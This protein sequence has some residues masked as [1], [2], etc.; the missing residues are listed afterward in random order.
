MKIGINCH[1]FE[2]E[3]GGPVRFVVNMLKYWP[4]MSDAHEYVLYF[5]D[6]VP[7]DD[8][9][10]HPTF[11]CK[12]VPS[13][14]WYHQVLWEHIS[15][16]RAVSK[17]KLDLFF[18]PWYYHPVFFKCPK[19][20]VAAWDITYS[21]HPEMYTGLF[22]KYFSITSRRSCKKSDGVMTCSYFDGR[23]I[24]KYYGIDEDRICVVQ[25]EPESKFVPVR[26]EAKI[27]ALKK[28][29]HL[30]EKFLLAM[31]SMYNRRHIDVIIQAFERLQHDHPDMGLVVCGKNATTPHVDIEALLEPLR[32]QGKA[33]YM[34]R[35]PEEDM[36]MAYNA[37]EWY[38]CVSD[39]DGE[40]ILLK[41]AMR[42]GTPVISSPL[43]EEAVG[44]HAI[45][46]DDPSNC[47]QMEQALRKAFTSTGLREDLS[48]NGL[49]WAER[50]NSKEN[51]EKG[52]R[53]LEQ[54]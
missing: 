16:A 47:D 32:A 40:T 50:F 26:D 31:G 43:L 2:I 54:C 14:S 4:Q 23:Q 52:L 17:D 29:H 33:V 34:Q 12:T 38:I 41:E 35:M 49:I 6:E 22:Q 10:Q 19:K 37:A 53:F 11:T 42:C 51:A 13:P 7:D 18:S 44:E 25:F 45:M 8:F 36:V 21:T 3:R 48:K 27:A 24:E 30:P 9:F 39:C 20:V 15:L 5:K 46:V 28:K 1:L